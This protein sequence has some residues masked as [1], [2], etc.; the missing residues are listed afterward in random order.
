MLTGRTLAVVAAADDDAV[1]GFLGSL[2][3][4]GITD[5]E[6]ELGQVRNVGAVGQDLGTGRHDV[7]GGDVIADFQNGLCGEGVGE[8]LTLGEF[9]DIGTT[10]DFGGC[11]FL[12][13]KGGE[14]CGIIDL[15]GC[16]QN[17][18]R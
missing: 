12:D 1:A 10:Q 9:L 6:A 18:L 5:L 4:A 7:V 15:E 13:G 3:E 16:G 14:D 11:G 8:G 2:R 17:S